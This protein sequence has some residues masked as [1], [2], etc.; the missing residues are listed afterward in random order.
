MTGRRVLVATGAAVANVDELPPLVRGLLDAAS[1]VLVIRLSCRAAFSG[2]FP[3][4]IVLGT[5]P[6]SG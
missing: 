5:R 4:P 2:W 1:D 6:T 3:T